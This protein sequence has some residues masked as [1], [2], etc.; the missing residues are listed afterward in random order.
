MPRPPIVAP[1]YFV[2]VQT[3]EI[4]EKLSFKA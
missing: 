3:G 2:N 1:P 4:I